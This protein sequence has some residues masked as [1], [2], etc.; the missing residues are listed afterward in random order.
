[1][2]NGAGTLIKTYEYSGNQPKAVDSSMVDKDGNF[3][4]S[5]PQN[6]YT[7]IGIGETPMTAAL[8]I[9]NSDDQIVVTGTKENWIQ[10]YAI[11]GSEH[12]IA[13]KEYF[14]KRQEYSN[15]IQ[16]LKAEMQSVGQNNQAA[17]DAINV[18][19]MAMQEAFETYKYNFIAENIN[20][21]A[22]YAAYQDIFD[23]QKD[24]KILKDMSATL[25]KYM[26]NTVF[27]Q[28]VEQKYQQAI[29]MKQQVQT[30]PPPP[31]GAIKVGSPAPELNF[32]GVDGKNIS[33]KSLKGKVVLLDFWASW[34]GP[35]RKENPNVVKL[36]NQYK[37]KGFTVY[38]FSLDQDKNKWINAIQA[39][40][41]I[42]PNHTSDLK[43]WNS[44]GGAIYNVNSIPVTY[45]I[46]TDGKIIA[47][48]LRGIELENKL[49][50]ILG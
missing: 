3:S 22:V 37:D 28:A 1:M 38:S 49:K 27:S 45:L 42:W 20:S 40:G 7:F 30:P 33:L 26:P 43:G 19:G 50:E 46:G 25:S 48:G 35:C 16:A 18:R 17:L 8:I 29:Q 6:G 12:S 10:D 4:F 32:P 11:S 39:D 24:E 44:A 41:L 31:A 2:T 15:G 34:C 13:M 23:L 21:P 9:A 14:Q 5:N 36:Y 47:I